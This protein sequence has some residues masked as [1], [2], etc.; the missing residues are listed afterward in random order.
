M[1]HTEWKVSSN[2]AH[3][4]IHTP[5]DLYGKKCWELQMTSLLKPLGQCC[6]N[7]IWSLPWAR[8]WK[9]AKTVAVHWPR[10]PPCSYMVETFKNLLQNQ[11]C[12]VAE[13]LHKSSGDSRSTKV[14]NIMVIHWHLTF[15]QS[16]QVCFPMHLH[17]K[18]CWEFQTTSSL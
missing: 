11:E 1:G 17:W 14:A 18:K 15:L 5:M 12:L 6:S 2:K 13:S 9:I 4:P 16:G 7:F 8:E 10:W 3:I